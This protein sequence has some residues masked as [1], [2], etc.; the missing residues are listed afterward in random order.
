MHLTRGDS[1][2]R[3]LTSGPRGWPAGQTPWPVG[4]T[5]QP[6]MGWL[7]GHALQEAVTRN[8]KLEVGGNRTR[9]PLGHVARPAGQ[10]LA[11]YGLN[12]GGNFSLDPLLVEFKTP[13]YICS[14]P[15]VKVLV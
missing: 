6:L 1:V 7:H 15:L 4:P 12:Q 8:L 13:H 9:W 5:L 3:P 11:C 2:Q 10:H 14:S